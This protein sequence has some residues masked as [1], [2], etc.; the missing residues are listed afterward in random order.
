MAISRAVQLGCV[1]CVCVWMFLNTPLFFLAQLT[2]RNILSQRFLPLNYTSVF[3][4]GHHWNDVYDP[5]PLTGDGGD[6]LT[7]CG[8]ITSDTDINYFTTYH[9]PSFL[10]AQTKLNNKLSRPLPLGP[11]FS[12]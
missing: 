5:P 1:W 11:A 12:S 9:Y 10:S 8:Y 2:A 3:S 4:L 7:R 6:R